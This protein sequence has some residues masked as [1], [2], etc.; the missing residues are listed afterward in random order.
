[1][2]SVKKG[3]FEIGFEKNQIITR[4]DLI[5]GGNLGSTQTG[6]TE[7]TGNRPPNYEADCTD[8]LS[9]AVNDSV[10]DTSP[11]EDGCE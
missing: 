7:C 9:G 5:Q 10:Y 6:D 2:K 4:L 11:N 1:M 8:S 3:L